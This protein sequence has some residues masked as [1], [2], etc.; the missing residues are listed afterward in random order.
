MEAE[1]PLNF[2]GRDFNGSSKPLATSIWSQ[3]IRCLVIR[4]HTF[5]HQPVGSWRAIQKRLFRSGTNGSTNLKKKYPRLRRSV[6]R[7]RWREHAESTHNVTRSTRCA[8][9]RRAFS[10][11]SARALLREFSSR[12]PAHSLPARRPA[13]LAH[14]APARV[15]EL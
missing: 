11:E 10:M 6:A 4:E 12:A 8:R 14:R 9:R 15:R 2:C 5:E 7:G 1:H 3:L 13:C